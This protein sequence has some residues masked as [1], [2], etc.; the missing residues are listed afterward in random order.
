MTSKQKSL[1]LEGLKS[2][3]VIFIVD[4]DLSVKRFSPQEVT[5]AGEA[6][7]ALKSNLE[8]GLVW[9]RRNNEVYEC[10]ELGSSHLREMCCFYMHHAYSP[11]L[12][13][14]SEWVEKT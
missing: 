2:F 4:K 5:D 6:G 12:L 1:L 10:L 7:Y 8:A 9:F 13:K 14:F 3:D 11:G